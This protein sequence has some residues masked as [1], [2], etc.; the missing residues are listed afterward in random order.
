MGETPPHDGL[1]GDVD[2]LWIGNL[3]ICYDP[4]DPDAYLLKRISDD[5]D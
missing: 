4:E 2:Y 1:H 3:T 5:D